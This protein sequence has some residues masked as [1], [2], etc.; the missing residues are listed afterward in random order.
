MRQPLPAQPLLPAA[1]SGDSADRPPKRDWAAPPVWTADPAAPGE[2]EAPAFLTPP[3]DRGTSSNAGAGG[4]AA[5]AA[6]GLAGSRWLN[7]APAVPSDDPELVDLDRSIEADQAARQSREPAAVPAPSDDDLLERDAAVAAVATASAGRR[8]SQ[9][10][11]RQ[12][13]PSRD[14]RPPWERSRRNEAYPTLKTRMGMPAIPRIA[15]AIGALVIAAVVIFSLPF[16]LNFGGSSTPTTPPASAGPSD[17]S[18]ASSGPS[19][20]VAPVTPTAQIYIVAAGDT[21]SKIAKKFGLTVA[22]LEAANPQIKNPNSIKIGDKITIPSCGRPDERDQRGI[23]QPVL[24]RRTN[25]SA[26]AV[27]PSAGPG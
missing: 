3:P 1:T 17:N 13:P 10:S 25:P 4:A 24:R 26:R 19:S 21:M 6:A 7:D 27:A 12:P 14:S 20:S 15:L 22:Q 16:L 2:V 18:L 8:A 5:G 11:R 23:A 9:V